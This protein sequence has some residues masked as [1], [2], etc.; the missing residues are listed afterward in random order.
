LAILI[1]HGIDLYGQ[2]R[3]GR[4]LERSV[5]TTWWK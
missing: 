3:L 2:H 4:S 1:V 5:W